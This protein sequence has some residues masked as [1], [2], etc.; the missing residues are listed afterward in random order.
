MYYSHF[1]LSGPPFQLTSSPAALYMSKE[2]REAYAALEWGLLHES[3]GFTVLVGEVGTGKTTLVLAILAR[4]YQNVRPI[5]LNN[6]KL[7]FEEM[8]KVIL[9]QLGLKAQRRSRLADLEAFGGF[10]LE[11]PAGERVVIIID[12]AQDLSDETMEQLRLLSNSGKP[13]EKQLHFLFVGQPELLRRLSS[14]S[15]RQL[16]QRIG[17]RSVLN[18][19][20]SGEVREYI[21]QRLQACGGSA[22]RVFRSGALRQIV[23]HSAGIPRRINVLCHNAML[24]AYSANAPLV[25]A[26]MVQAAVTEYDGLFA[27]KRARATGSATGMRR[28]LSRALEST[29][30]RLLAWSRALNP[31]DARALEA[32]SSAASPEPAQACAVALEKP[33]SLAS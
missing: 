10:L 1:G 8:L 32:G 11:L 25:D 22:K 20:Q 12:E 14:P 4:E 29:G 15:L 9:K 6:P 13:D 31:H 30:L 2:H 27:L 33:E 24:L 23:R 18:P 21:D 5:Y 16:D 28:W 7:S 3:S 19:L 17:A 26:Q